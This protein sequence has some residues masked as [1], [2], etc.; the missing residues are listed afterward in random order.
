M[1]LSHLQGHSYCKPFKRDFYA[2]DAMQC[3]VF[4]CYHRESVRRLSVRSS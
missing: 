4:V 1:T 3:A 2:R